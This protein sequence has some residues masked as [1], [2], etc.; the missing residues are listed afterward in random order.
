MAQPDAFAALFLGSSMLLLASLA[1]GVLQY[2]AQRPKPATPSKQ[3]ESTAPD[4]QEK[5]AA[6]D[7]QEK[8]AK[9]GRQRTETLGLISLG[10]PVVGSA[11]VVWG[12]FREAGVPTWQAFVG[13]GVAVVVVAISTYAAL[14]VE[15]RRRRI[16][17]VLGVSLAIAVFVIAVYLS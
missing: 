3:K 14:R 9:R 10:A 13:V 15:A 2:N 17:L 1:S 5:S 4:E 12:T 8:S 11:A 6:P 7:E 16:E